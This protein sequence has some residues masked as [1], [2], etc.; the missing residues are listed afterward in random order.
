MCVWKKNDKKIERFKSHYL[1]EINLN[2]SNKSKKHYNMKAEMK[3]TN[4]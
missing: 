2:K 3:V 4:Q 1:S